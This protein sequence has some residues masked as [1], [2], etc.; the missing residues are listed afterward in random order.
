MLNPKK[1]FL[2]VTTPCFEHE[3]VEGF[4]ERNEKG[5]GKHKIMN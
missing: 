1:E 4:M 3:F 2:K 5:K